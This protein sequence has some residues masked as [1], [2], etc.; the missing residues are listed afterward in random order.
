MRPH[1]VCQKFDE[2]RK[3]MNIKL[4]NFLYCVK[5]LFGG[6][7]PKQL[8]D[9]GAKPS[10][11]IKIKN[12]PLLNKEPAP[13]TLAAKFKKDKIEQLMDDVRSKMD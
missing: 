12:Y 5:S 9:L 1:C 10:N 6:K 7:K 13:N 8:D 4:R 11:E 3:N 2:N